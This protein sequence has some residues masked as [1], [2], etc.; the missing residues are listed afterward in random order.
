MELFIDES[1][2]TGCV[3]TTHGKFNFDK[4]RHFVLCAIKTENEDEKNILIQKYKIFKDTFNVAEEIKGS[5]LMTRRHNDELQYF[6]DNILDDKHFEICIYD[7][8]FYL[9]TLLLLFLLGNEFQTMFPAQFYMLAA[10]LYFYGEDLLLEYCEIAKNPTAEL[11]EKLLKKI[12][13]HN[14][15]EIP[16]NNNPLIML[17]DKILAD[18][19]Y[20]CWIKD[21]LSYGSYENSNYVNVINLNCLSELILS[22]KWRNNLSNSTIKIHHD[23]IDGYDKAFTSELNDFDIDLDFVDS[24]KEELIQIADNAVSI[25]AKCVNE[26]MLRFEEKREW[27]TD[28]RWIMEQYAKILTKVSITNIKFVIPPQNWAVSLC[29][30][31]M[32]NKNYPIEKRKNLFFNPIYLRNLNLIFDD[33]ISKNFDFRLMLDLLKK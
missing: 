18:K 10:E 17:A 14:Y 7:K 20:D 8:K 9:S 3:I 6:V 11:F 23:R 27:D 5:D 2:N 25:F 33:I 29:V 32:F 13:H 22:L 16:P 31:E 19:D 28:S 21:I 24:K 15:K 1:G 4:Q 26:V 12:T 30:Q